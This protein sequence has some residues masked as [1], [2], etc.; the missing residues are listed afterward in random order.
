MADS[1]LGIKRDRYSFTRVQVF[2]ENQSVT[3]GDRRRS[4]CFPH[5]SFQLW[6]ADGRGRQVDEGKKFFAV[7]EHAAAVSGPIYQIH[8]MLIFRVTVVLER[9]ELIACR[10]RVL[11]KRPADAFRDLPCPL[12]GPGLRCDPNDCGIER[13]SHFILRERHHVGR[14]Y[15]E[16]FSIPVGHRPQD[17]FPPWISRRLKYNLQ[18]RDL[19][20]FQFRK[21]ARYSYERIVFESVKHLEG[22]H[23]FMRE[24]EV[25]NDRFEN[26]PLIGITGA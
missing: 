19:A 4:F 2:S 8:D 20:L 23:E 17:A 14:I 10:V 24:A 9:N 5:L 26:D 12:A 21:C 7:Q 11:G 22:T 16:R 6:N 18:D 15:K 13:A 3:D 25:Y 1:L